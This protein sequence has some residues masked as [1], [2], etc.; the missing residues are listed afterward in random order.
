MSDP[1]DLRRFVDA[2]AQTYDQAL[3]ELRAGRKR[4]HWMWFVFPQVEGLGRSGMAQRYAVSGL[5]EARAY[6]AHPVLG[7]RLV[8]CARAMTA[9]DTEDA[10]AVLGP[11]D[12][13]K[14][15]SS[16]TL[17]AHADPDQPVFREVLDHYFGGAED[18]A[19]TSRL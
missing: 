5:D 9:L 10:D 13:Q 14:L 17:F 3:A 16:M 1:F 19:T 2:Q 12:A 18:D 7:R 4:T 8:E 6:L 11:V 15:R